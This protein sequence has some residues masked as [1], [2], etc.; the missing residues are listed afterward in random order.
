MNVK[1]SEVTQTE[2]KELHNTGMGNDKPEHKCVFM[3]II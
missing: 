2:L 3:I 1:Y